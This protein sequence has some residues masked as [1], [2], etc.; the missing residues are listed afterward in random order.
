[1]LMKSVIKKIMRKI[2]F[3]ISHNFYV[4]SSLIGDDV[5]VGNRCKLYC[6]RVVGK[7]DIGENT[8]V[9]GPN[10]HIL[11]K[12]N[13]I[14]I[15]K[16]CSISHNVTLIEYSH[17]YKKPS[18]YY[19][20][21]N[22]LGKSVEYDL[23]SKG[24]III[25]NDVWVGSGVT[26]LGGVNVGNGA[27]IAANSVVTKDVSAYSIVAGNPAKHIKMRFSQDKIKYLED[28]KWWDL[29]IDR[30]IEKEKFFTSEL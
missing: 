29:S 16:F 1:M 3:F 4:R 2:K 23:V 11:S 14:K 8:S 15:G 5:I 6:V 18:S 9:Y 17:N 24:P 10:T 26:I 20:H 7:V 19:Y 28:L 22:I 12:I 30:L 27:V 13:S 21:Q 25:G